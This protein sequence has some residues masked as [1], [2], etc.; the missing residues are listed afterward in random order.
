MNAVVA[1][2]GSLA[3]SFGKLSKKLKAEFSPLSAWYLVEALDGEALDGPLTA[4]IPK[5]RWAVDTR[6]ASCGLTLRDEAGR[7]NMVCCYM[8][9]RGCN[10]E[11]M[12]V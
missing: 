9:L 1:G 3:C 7:G 11:R 8:M 5:D 2:E 12:C 10:D 4:V 6:E